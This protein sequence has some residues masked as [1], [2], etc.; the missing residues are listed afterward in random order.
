MT[1]WTRQGSNYYLY[2]TGEE[3]EISWAKV[4]FQDPFEPPP[5]FIPPRHTSMKWWLIFRL[6]GKKILSHWLHSPRGQQVEA[7]TEILRTFLR[8]SGHFFLLL[9][10]MVRVA[11]M[12]FL[13]LDHRLVQSVWKLGAFQ[14]NLVLQEVALSLVLLT[15][16]PFLFCFKAD[17]LHQ[18][19]E[20]LK[21][22]QSTLA[23]LLLL[24]WGIP[25]WQ[26]R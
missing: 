7:S 12:S 19:L 3:E 1:L 10:F 5:S 8:I 9:H 25:L 23:S 26:A 2:L 18:D 4:T 17:C 22:L 20:D 6:F 24:H 14:T 16:M 15:L 21:E 11:K 13:A